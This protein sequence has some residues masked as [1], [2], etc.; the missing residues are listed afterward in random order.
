MSHVLLC[1]RYSLH[2]VTRDAME[3][4][5]RGDASRR[6]GGRRRRRQRAAVRPE[7]RREDFAR[8]CC[9]LTERSLEVFLSAHNQRL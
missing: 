4:P 2:N 3:E 8:C 5:W 7:V 9:H 6:Q 1:V